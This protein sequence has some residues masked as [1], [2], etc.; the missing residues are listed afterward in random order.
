[1][2]RALAAAALLGCSLV[3]LA[4]CSPALAPESPDGSVREAVARLATLQPVGTDPDAVA[5]TF[6]LNTRSTE[7]QREALEKQLVGN[8]VQWPVKVYEVAQDGEAYKI[9]SQPIP[10]TDPNATPL[11]R[12]LAVVFPQSEL[13]RNAIEALRTGDT[14]AVKGFVRSV[15]LRTVLTIHPAV[16]AGAPSR[17]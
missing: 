1:M 15:T 7:L 6:A 9:L 8:V 11:L 3:A 10:I 2:R 5:E 14:V 17:T 16:L 12:V 4:G 13:D